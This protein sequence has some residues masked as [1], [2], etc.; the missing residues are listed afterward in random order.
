MEDAKVKTVF[1]APAEGASVNSVSFLL[2]PN[3][4]KP[5]YIAELS[6]GKLIRISTRLGDYLKGD[7][8]GS[9]QVRDVAEKFNLH[10]SGLR[11]SVEIA[12]RGKWTVSSA[13]KIQYELM[14]PTGSWGIFEKL[15]KFLNPIAFLT[16]VVLLFGVGVASVFLRSEGAGYSFTT[17]LNLLAFLGV[18]PAIFITTVV[19]EAAH[20]LMLLRYGHGM[21]RAG[22]MLFFFMPSAFCD[23]TPAWLLPRRQRV[24]VCLAGALTQLGLAGAALLTATFVSGDWRQ[25]LD[26]YGAAIALT[27]FINLIP[28]VKFDGYLALISWLDEPALIERARKHVG[29]W[30]AELVVTGKNTTQFEPKLFLFGVMCHITPPVLVVAAL[31]S[32]MGTLVSLGV[33]GRVL[34]CLALVVI[35]GSLILQVTGLVMR[36]K[37]LGATLAQRVATLSLIAGLCAVALLIPVEQS[38]SGAFE[39]P[40]AN[41]GTATVVIPPDDEGNVPVAQSVTLESRGMVRQSIVEVTLPETSEAC[42]TDLLAQTPFYLPDVEAPGQGECFEVDIDVDTS[43]PEQGL[44]SFDLPTLTMAE[45]LYDRAIGIYLW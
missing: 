19:H 45:Y 13:L 36:M 2:H 24:V 41:S 25:M 23:V 42:V 44:V 5:G 20:A 15:A 34:I 21:R 17:P 10:P 12:P 11:D 8:A 3:P 32:L 30:T 1:G 26:L 16:I 43:L 18:L 38:G 28:F 22:L 9:P 37:L 27:A 40:D 29:D 4:E 6:N 7:H 35:L 39:R 33:V 14:S 31:G